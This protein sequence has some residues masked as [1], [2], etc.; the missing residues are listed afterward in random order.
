MLG[1]DVVIFFLSLY[2]AHLLN[3]RNN[4]WLRRVVYVGIFAAVINTLLT[5]L[6][7]IQAFGEVSTRLYLVPTI[8]YAAQY[9]AYLFLVYTELKVAS[10]VTQRDLQIGQYFAIISVLGASVAGVG[11]AYMTVVGYDF[12]K[13]YSWGVTVVALDTLFDYYTFL[14]LWLRIY[15]PKEW[16]LPLSAKVLMPLLVCIKT[17]LLIIIATPIVGSFALIQECANHIAFLNV[18]YLIIGTFF[19]VGS[20]KT[21][22]LKRW[23]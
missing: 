12:V 6:C 8:F 10:G 20:I 1:V 3:V 17:F 21:A 13:V 18:L 2:A 11:Y 22:L 16:Q 15:R 7:D 9:I 19:M 5:Y 23:W 4:I 14:I